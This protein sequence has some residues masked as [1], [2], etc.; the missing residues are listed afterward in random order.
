MKHT[1][2][3]VMFAMGHWPSPD[4]TRVVDRFH[5]KLC[6]EYVVVDVPDMKLKPTPDG[7][8]KEVPV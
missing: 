4:R 1:C 5:C 8:F 7:W 2:G 3:N 6:D